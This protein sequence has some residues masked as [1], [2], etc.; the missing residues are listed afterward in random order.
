MA[1]PQAPT[2]T[3]AVPCP[4]FTPSASISLGLPPPA[5]QPPASN[6][7]NGLPI[8]Q[9]LVDLS[10]WQSMN[11]APC[12]PTTLTL[13]S[14]WPTSLAAA[15]SG[16]C[17]DTS[18]STV[19]GAPVPNSPSCCH[20]FGTSSRWLTQCQTSHHTIASSCKWP[21]PLTLSVS[22][23]QEKL[24]G[25]RPVTAQL[26]SQSC[27]S[28]GPPTMPSSPCPPPRPTPFNKAFAWDPLALDPSP[29]PS[30]LPCSVMPS[31]PLASLP[32]IMPAI[33][34]AKGQPHGPGN[35][36]PPPLTSSHWAGGA[37]TATNVTSTALPL[38]S[39]N[40][41]HPPSSPFTMGHCCQPALP[42]MTLGASNSVSWPPVLVE[43]CPQLHL[44]LDHQVGGLGA[45]KLEF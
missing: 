32:W 8:S 23:S 31:S 6:F 13:A 36:A 10:I 15:S 35:M 25:I 3:Q 11:S 38:T 9:H 19:L 39:T 28:N 45:T 34:F 41:W 30:S 42:D 1:L 26:S 2:T 5:S 18:T 24:F 14:T 12:D 43:D 4:T 33:P 37:P 22:C 16:L 20:S 44:C 27:W 17:V 7:S 40:L 21:T 29:T